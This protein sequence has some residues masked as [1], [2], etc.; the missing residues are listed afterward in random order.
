MT[1]ELSKAILRA[2]DALNSAHIAG[3]QA[4]IGFDG[5]VDEIIEAVDKRTSSDTYTKI[6]TI[7]ELGERITKAA[8]LSTNI[9]LVPKVIKLG[10]NGPIMANA[11]AALGLDITYIGAVGQPLHPV[12]REL[13]L[14]ARVISIADPGHTDALEFSD[15][16]VML[17]KLETIKD[18]NWENLL[19]AIPLPQLI[20]LFS[21]T[22]LIATVNWTMIPYMTELW[23]H[24]IDDVFT[25]TAYEE[26]PIIFFDLADPEKRSR[27]EIVEA[28]ETIQRFDGPCRATL[29]LN[30]KEATAVAEALGLELSCDPAEAP[31]DEITKAIAERMGIY[32]VV[33]HPL[34][35]AACVVNGAFC[36]VDGPYTAQ[37]KL[38]TG[39]GDN[40]NAGFCLGQVLNLYPKDCLVLGTAA[41]GF[42]VRY[43]HSPSRLELLSFLDLWAGHVGEYFA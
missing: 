30:R 33:V 43:E 15:G 3:T 40:F 39:A 26:P 16:K 20:E 7:A 36:I 35:Q 10:G 42:Y 41:S 23:Q 27:G 24:L 2:K 9:E 4:V 1:A 5:F 14:K 6:G 8:G 18:I 11:L 37:P 17:G 22:K 31:L 32:G 12:F 38:T 29:G 19:A 34:A 25:A 21:R 28:L 13:A